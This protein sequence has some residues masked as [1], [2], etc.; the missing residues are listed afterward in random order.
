M[1]KKLYYSKKG[2]AKLLEDDDWCED[3]KAKYRTHWA[4]RDYNA[5]GHRTDR[6]TYETESLAIPANAI[7]AFIGRSG[8]RV[9]ELQR[10]TKGLQRVNVAAELGV[11]QVTGS[12]AATEEVK[13]AIRLAASEAARRT[14]IVA[15]D[16]R[17]ILLPIDGDAIGFFVGS[18]GRN[19]KELQHAEGVLSISIEGTNVD[20]TATP[21]AMERIRRRIDVATSAASKKE[22]ELLNQRKLTVVDLPSSQSSTPS[23][24]TPS[25]TPA[26]TPT[27]GHKKNPAP[28][29]SARP[30]STP[31]RNAEAGSSPLRKK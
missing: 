8:A 16:V 6:P 22:V 13:R 18:E 2:A 27:E 3:S 5:G 12:P 25:S 26:A 14:T 7:G 19:I 24:T 11:V 29:S 10:T 21:A 17:R 15:G 23:A 4:S 30:R 9:K 20:A 28:S 1:S 31:P